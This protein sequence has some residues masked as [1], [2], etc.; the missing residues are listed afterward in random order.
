[1]WENLWALLADVLD[2]LKDVFLGSK[3]RSSQSSLKITGFACSIAWRA[4]RRTGPG[5]VAEGDGHLDVEMAEDEIERRLRGTPGG[6]PRRSPRGARGTGWRRPSRTAP[7]R[8]RHLLHG[9]PGASASPARRSSARPPRTARSAPPAPASARRRCPAWRRRRRIIA[10]SLGSVLVVE[11][12]RVAGMG[13]EVGHVVPL[14]H[15]PAW[16]AAAS[17][18]MM[19]APGFSLAMKVWAILPISVGHRH[20]HDVGFRSACPDRCKS[21]RGGLEPSRPLGDLDMVTS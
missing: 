13:D 3:I 8:D 20:Q 7:A 2:R 9:S 4:P 6:P 10:S 15:S 21:D 17:S 19:A 11:D 16:G 5:E 1:M 18:T 12:R 14:G